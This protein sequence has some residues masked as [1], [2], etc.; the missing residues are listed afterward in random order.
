MLKR[1]TNHSEHRVFEQISKA[2]DRFGAEVYRK[3]RVADVVDING[4]SASELRKYALMAH[5][6]FIVSDDNHYPLFALEFDGGGHNDVNDWKKDRICS[7]ENLALFRVD[8]QTLDAQLKEMSFLQYLV[9]VWFMAL[10]FERIKKLGEIPEDEPFVMWGFLKPDAKHI[11][12]S[13]YNFTATALKK[14]RELNKRHRFT[15]RD[16]FGFGIGEV[17]L[18]KHM[19]K[20]VSFTSCDIGKTTI[21]GQCKSNLRV[22]CD[23]LLGE[24][25]FGRMALADFV[26][27]QAHMSLADS[28]QL[29]FEGAGH[30]LS[31]EAEILHQISTLK[32]DG[33]S[34]CRGGGI[35]GHGLTAAISGL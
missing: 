15:D 23:G 27:G 16:H 35:E 30:T 6:D 1:L 34:L 31:S 24:I 14:I 10:E 29:Y 21:F 18:S 19:E 11:F 28:I 26:C 22:P 32:K 25:P 17:V 4:L 13:E 12:D 3:I 8:F 20:F 5:F 2:C 33:Y 7:D 9:H